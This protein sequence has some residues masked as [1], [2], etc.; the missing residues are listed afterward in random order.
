MVCLC[1][2]LWYTTLKFCQKDPIYKGH[3]PASL[4]SHLGDRLPRFTPEELQV[5]H[6]SSDFF[7]LNTYTSNVV[8]E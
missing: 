7:G 6:G 8:R 3:Y 5:V 4:V 2:S 1:F